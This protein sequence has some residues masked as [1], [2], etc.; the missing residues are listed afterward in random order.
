MP[1]SR[2]HRSPVKSHSEE[3]ADDVDE[4]NMSRI[5][6][7]I[8]RIKGQK[9]RPGEERICATMLFKYGVEQDMTLSIL[10]KAVQ[11][12]RVVKLI[13][14]GMPSYRDPDNLPVTRGVLNTSDLHR[15]VKKAILSVNLG[16]CTFKEIE[17]YICSDCNL[18]PSP[19]LT[20]QLKASIGK[21]MEQ[22]KLERRG[23]LYRVPIAR[24][25]PFPQPSV[26]PS[27]VCSFCL[28]TAEQNRDSQPE[29]LVS[30]HECGNSGHPTCLK[31]SLDLVERIKAEPWLCLECKKCMVCG[32]AANADDLL[33]CDACD[34]GFH[35]ECLDPPLGE[36]PEGCWICPVCVPPPNRRR[37]GSSSRS[38]EHGG[39]DTPTTKRPRKS[40][41]SY[42]SDY[43]TIKGS[44]GRKKKA[45]LKDDGDFD[46]SMMLDRVDEEVAPPL[47]PGVEESDLIL[48]KKA[49]EKALATSLNGK[50]TLD[51]AVR[52]PPMIEFGKYEIKTWFSSPY[53]Q[54][55]AMLPKLY[56][57]EFCLKYMKSRSIL[58]RHRA[59]C[60]WFHPPANEI[61]RKDDLSIF[62]VDGM[63]SKIYCQNLCLLAKLFL[64]HKTL[65]YDV[66]PFLFYVLTQNDRK[67]C[68]LVGYFSKEKS[69]QQ[70]YNVS[71]IMTMPQYQRQGFG[72]F[73]ID[74]SYLLSR[75]EEQP[76][77]PE[78]PLSDLGR[79]SYYSYW[80]STIME[81]LYQC[82]TPKVSIR[83]MSRDLGMDP[84]D[85][86]ATLQMLNMLSLRP[87]GRV[88]VSKNRAILEAH[89]EGVRSG[90]SKRI[91][92]DPS[93]LHWSPLVN[94]KPAT[95]LSVGEDSE[96]DEVC[97]GGESG[98]EGGGHEVSMD[99]AVGMEGKTSD[100]VES[101][102]DRVEERTQGEMEKRQEVEESEEEQVVHGGLAIDGGGGN[103]KTLGEVNGREEMERW[104]E[105]DSG[106]GGEETKVDRVSQDR[107]EEEGEP[108]DA[109]MQIESEVDASVHEAEGG[110]SNNT[111]RQE[112]SV[113]EEGNED[114][115]DQEEEED[116][117]NVSVEEQGVCSVDGG[118]GS[119]D[120]EGVVC[121]TDEPSSDTEDT[122]E[123]QETAAEK[124]DKSRG[125]EMNL[126]TDDAIRS[127]A[128]TPGDTPERDSH[129]RRRQ[130]DPD[131]PLRRSARKM[132]VPTTGRKPSHKKA[133]SLPLD[134]KERRERH[135]LP[136]IDPVSART[137]SRNTIEIGRGKLFT[138]GISNFEPVRKRRKTTMSTSSADVRVTDDDD[139]QFRNAGDCS[140][141]DSTGFCDRRN[142]QSRRHAEEEEEGGGGREQNLAHRRGNF[143]DYD[144]DNSSQRSTSP[145]PKRWTHDP[146]SDLEGSEN[147]SDTSSSSSSLF[148]AQ[149][150]GKGLGRGYATAREDTAEVSGG[151]LLREEDSNVEEFDSQS[152]NECS[153]RRGPARTEESARVDPH[154]GAGPTGNQV[155]NPRPGPTRAPEVGSR[156]DAEEP[157]ETAKLLLRLSEAPCYSV[158]PLPAMLGSNT[159][160][161]S[162]L[163][164]LNPPNSSPY[165]AFHSQ[166][167]NPP[168][169][170][171]ERGGLPTST[172][173]HHSAFL[174]MT[175]TESSELSPGGGI[176]RSPFPKTLMNR[177]G[178]TPHPFSLYGHPQ[179]L[180]SYFMP[181]PPPRPLTPNTYS[182]GPPFPY[183]HMYPQ[184]PFN[185][186][187][188]HPLS[189]QANYWGRPPPYVS[190]Q[191]QQVNNSEQ[192][193]LPSSTSS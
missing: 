80:K 12:G 161:E 162:S 120:H 179:A 21:Q 154:W 131:T 7:T 16:G 190:G 187:P 68:H 29:E 11:A 116:L 52:S 23:R 136:Y 1:R 128:P 193:H 182:S 107:E 147:E 51:P 41:L 40:I 149:D 63:A 90:K 121:R 84:H 158:H 93:S 49:Q 102:L 10:D 104:E 174:P 139:E 106:P 99:I 79:V 27:A 44:G 119:V 155:P 96:E 81:Y 143:Q 103:V 117:P 177:V 66:E 165:E 135:S 64:D 156:S 169:A 184:L 183:M 118:C 89:M 130:L 125:G 133:K 39:E 54:E 72:R 19:E 13:N 166:S 30:C 61:Y 112:N 58:K 181:S 132:P 134:R 53:P 65:Y 137:R 98:K 173:G 14:K 185:R 144:E 24:A 28:G 6:A 146:C 192:Q 69:C 15:M 78:K 77:S 32:Q 111:S 178:S 110:T 71:C 180:Q 31:Y 37:T 33:I 35:M 74:F 83:K 170:P 141:S 4:E 91:A 157:S 163:N 20:E 34:K 114:S 124:Q 100:P 138:L 86:A 70:K 160:Q 101:G 42:F 115:Q 73:L 5:L 38:Q 168:N 47:P 148:I 22:G 108:G 3:K 17:D 87:G 2:K 57:C 140:A 18:V 142:Y 36:L 26:P 9:Q 92:L 8:H 175:H 109:S 150:G 159:Q 88:I 95:T 76:G 43:C 56:I 126:S 45:L 75:I 122:R 127:Y 48:F 152:D 60:F 82:D 151:R 191:Q 145:N 123:Q 62:E 171:L 59:K 67:G 172:F 153:E 113:F 105:K 188:L 94:P 189:M 164:Q 186:P 46:C 50:L 85:I 55:Y 167:T 25:D 176:P 97:V 129:R